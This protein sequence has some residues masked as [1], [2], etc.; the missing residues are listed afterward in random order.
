MG[1]NKF[2]TACS[3]RLDKAINKNDRTT[4]KNCYNE[5]KRKHKKNSENDAKHLDFSR[6]NKYCTKRTVHIWPF[7]S[8]KT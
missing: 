3:L 4:C 5:K 2:C 1:V 8:G 6:Y 7:F